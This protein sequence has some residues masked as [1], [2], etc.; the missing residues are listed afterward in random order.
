MH[1]AVVAA[2]VFFAG[3]A[4]VSGG[5][6]QGDPDG[7]RG[8]RRGEVVGFEPAADHDGFAEAEAVEGD[9]EAVGGI[10]AL[11]DGFAG[12]GGDERGAERLEA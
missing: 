4:L 2:V 6:S 7:A 1:V 8:K 10:G 3:D 9:G 11:E 12:I 5:F